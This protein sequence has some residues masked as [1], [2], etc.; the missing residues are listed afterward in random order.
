M[1]K[2]SYKGKIN[3]ETVNGRH[4]EQLKMDRLIKIEELERKDIILFGEMVERNYGPIKRKSLS[5]SIYYKN[6]EDLK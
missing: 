3:K 4:G 6:M 5:G 1:K 2:V